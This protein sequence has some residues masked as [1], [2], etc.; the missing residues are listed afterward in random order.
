MHTETKTCEQWKALLV[1][2][3]TG[4]TEFSTLQPAKALYGIHDH[5]P[6][7]ICFFI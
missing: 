4:F 3:Q 5:I 2:L 7:A 6:I 1:S